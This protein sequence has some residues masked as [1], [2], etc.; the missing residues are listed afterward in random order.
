[1]LLVTNSFVVIMLNRFLLPITEE[2]RVGTRQRT[3]GTCVMYYS[4]LEQ[5]L[6]A[7]IKMLTEWSLT[8]T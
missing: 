5:E 8:R 2:I 4:K 3:I 6:S 1:M 7:F